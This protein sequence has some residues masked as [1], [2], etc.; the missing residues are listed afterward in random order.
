MV[1]D[2]FNHATMIGEEKNIASGIPIS[3]EIANPQDFCLAAKRPHNRGIQSATTANKITIKEATRVQPRSQCSDNATAISV[4]TN[5]TAPTIISKMP[6]NRFSTS[7]LIG[8]TSWFCRQV[9]L[10]LPEYF[11]NHFYYSAAGFSQHLFTLKNLGK[12]HVS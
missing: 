4:S 12:T 10:A 11:F 5:N 1:W 6:I 2:Y 9:N 8:N 3:P 7:T